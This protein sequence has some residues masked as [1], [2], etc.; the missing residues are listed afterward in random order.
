MIGLLRA[1]AYTFEGH[2][3][4]GH[5][6]CHD[7]LYLLDLLVRHGRRS[8]LVYDHP[9]DDLGDGLDGVHRQQV[10]RDYLE[11]RLLGRETLG[12]RH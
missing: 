1:S 6:D 5:R 2:E 11:S 3:Y 8:C 7:H 12:G 4:V 10:S 9:Q